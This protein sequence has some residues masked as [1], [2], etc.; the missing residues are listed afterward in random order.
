M[1]SDWNFFDFS[2]FA[3]DPD[4]ADMLITGAHLDA[5]EPVE[6]TTRLQKK[7]KLRLWFHIKKNQIMHQV[8]NTFSKIYCSDYGKLFTE[9][10]LSCSIL[11][12]S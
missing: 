10:S 11:L 1:F 8:I 7:K 5:E 12:L 3:W 6:R 9:S 2:P 4:D